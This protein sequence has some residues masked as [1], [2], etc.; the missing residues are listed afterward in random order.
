[1]SSVPKDA[2][3]K[4]IDEIASFIVLE[5]TNIYETIHFPARIQTHLMIHTNV[6]FTTSKNGFSFFMKL[7]RNKSGIPYDKSGNVRKTKKEVNDPDRA[8]N[9]TNLSFSN[10]YSLCRTINIEINSDI[11]N[12]NNIAK[13]ME[14]VIRFKNIKTIKV[15]MPNN[16]F[17][18]LT[19]YNKITVE[20]KTVIIEMVFNPLISKN[21][22]LKK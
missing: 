7:S 10:K 8:T 16:L 15:K 11:K 21:S 5:P 1:M 18:F 20:S 3:L 9:N 12:T 4:D 14:I 17:F 2:V 19:S 13:I 22:N 6:A